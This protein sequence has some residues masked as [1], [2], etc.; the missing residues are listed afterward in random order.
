M[1]FRSIIDRFPDNPSDTPADN[2]LLNLPIGH[3]CID[4]NR[5]EPNKSFRAFL[6]SLIELDAA[7]ESAHE[8]TQ[9]G[10]STL[11]QSLIKFQF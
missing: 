2:Y 11:I 5:I 1:T 4:F 7:Y 10:I 6:K 9:N 8:Y 3:Q